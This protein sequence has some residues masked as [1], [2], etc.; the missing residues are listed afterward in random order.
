MDPAL[1]PAWTDG[2]LIDVEEADRGH[3]YGSR[4]VRRTALEVL[5]STD[6]TRVVVDVR[7][8]N[9]AAIAAYEKA[10]F[11]KVRFLAN[12]E[13]GDGDIAD[14]FLMEFRS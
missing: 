2:D 4:T 6:A 8:D 11:H 5:R 1:V 12:H 13:D 10:G 14:A 7:A 9:P 3:G